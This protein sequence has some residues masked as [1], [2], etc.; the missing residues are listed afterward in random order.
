M[1]HYELPLA[2]QTITTNLYSQQSE[3]VQLALKQKEPALI[4]CKVILSFHDVAK[5][6]VGRV[7]RDTIQQFSCETLCVLPYSPGHVLTDY[8]H[9]HSLY[10]NRGWRRAVK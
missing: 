5:P 1:G 9:F 2:G 6:H 10:K 3:G 7:A 8:D 4:N